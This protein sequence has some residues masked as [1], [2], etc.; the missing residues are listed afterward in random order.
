VLNST[1]TFC[2]ET[3]DL[4][5]FGGGVSG[6]QLTCDGLSWACTK[7]NKIPAIQKVYCQSLQTTTYTSTTTAKPCKPIVYADNVSP[8]PNCVPPIQSEKAADCPIYIVFFASYQE[9][10]VGGNMTC[11][12]GSWKNADSFNGIKMYCAPVKPLCEVMVYEPP[13]QPCDGCTPPSSLG[14]TRT[15]CAENYNLL[16]DDMVIGNLTCAEG[17]SF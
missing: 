11:V 13:P 3:Q 10:T 15:T 16:S 7:G 2:S 6:W 14:S 1:D 9:T 17:G 4:Y 12:K 8:C 5:Y